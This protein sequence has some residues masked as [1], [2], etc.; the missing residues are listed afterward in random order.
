MAKPRQVSIDRLRFGGRP[1]SA[2]ADR[3][4]L[5]HLLAG[6]ELWPAEMPPSAV[7][8]VR[9][10]VDPLPGRL[11]DAPG[12]L[13]PSPTWVNAVRVM[14]ADLW[15]HAA[16]AQNGRLEAGESAAAV[17]FRSGAEQAACLTLAIAEGAAARQWWQQEALGTLSR[18]TPAAALSSRPPG[19]LPAIFALLAQWGEA[20]A[21]ATRLSDPEAWALLQAMADAYELTWAAALPAPAVRDAAHGR[22]SELPGATGATEPPA[23]APA[24]PAIGSTATVGPHIERIPVASRGDTPHH[25][26]PPG[27]QQALLTLAL[28]LYHTPAVARSV[29]Y[30]RRFQRWWEGRG[31]KPDAPPRPPYQPPTGTTPHSTQAPHRPAAADGAET[32][33]E[34]PDDYEESLA[35]GVETRLGGLLYLINLLIRLELQIPEVGVWA[36]LEAVG[37]ALLDQV[38]CDLLDDP[39]WQLLALLDGR[40]PAYPAGQHCPPLPNPPT[41]P[42]E[43]PPIPQGPP[44]TPG[45]HSGNLSPH[46]QQWLTLLIPY[47]TAW[48]RAALQPAEDDWLKALLLVPARI[49]VTETQV[50]L[51]LPL[52]AASLPVR[53]AALDRTPG[54]QPQ[55]GRTITFY[56]E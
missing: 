32:A 35:E 52:Q 18:A 34:Q 30:A 26:S 4:R 29:A 3:L 49:H 54:W 50:D 2:V 15:R 36:L 45:P 23:T 16:R 14:L 17:A 20:E 42:P 48:L 55:F 37:R 51:V 33:E 41:L 5:E 13:W 56:F 6:A 46:L 12:D 19:E 25:A 28:A 11:V 40:E 22:R 21:V 24:P 39:I 53:L 1:E 10:L 9:R 27:A 38:D 47:L 44:Y 31:P 8:V 43:W 7:L